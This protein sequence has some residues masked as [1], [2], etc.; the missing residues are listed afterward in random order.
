MK[1]TG[2]EVRLEMEK[3]HFALQLWAVWEISSEGSVLAGC[4]HKT[5]C[6]K[7]VCIICFKGINE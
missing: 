3:P 6:L 4:T 1:L 2:H 5:T 7:K